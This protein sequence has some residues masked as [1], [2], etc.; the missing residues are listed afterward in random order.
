MT[1]DPHGDVTPRRGV[2]LA[3]LG[4]VENF[5]SRF[6]FPD[7]LLR[8]IAERARLRTVKRGEECFDL[9]PGR[10]IY[11]LTEGC[12]R[13]ELDLSH[14]RLWRSTI[15]G[16]WTGGGRYGGSRGT[17]LSTEAH[18]LFLGLDDVR[19]IGVVHPEFFL[20]LAVLSQARLEAA[21]TV[22]GASRLPPVTRVATLLSHL[23][24]Q[25]TYV[26]ATRP[27]YGGAKRIVRKARQDVVEGPTQAD[28]ADALGL[29]RAA[30]ENAI[31][32]LRSRGVLKQQP[33][34]SRVHRFYEID[35]DAFQD[36]MLE[37]L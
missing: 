22:Y 20:A 25:N 3:V 4:V 23:A 10:R 29:S 28:I 19:Q 2:R 32:D 21:E 15:F 5:F 27:V 8:M 16:D 17:V 7:P 11:L 18:G 24:S 6:G 30:V 37:T 35:R 1:R 31:R 13:E 14:T 34:M 33:G 12:I 36:L 26:Y 9:R